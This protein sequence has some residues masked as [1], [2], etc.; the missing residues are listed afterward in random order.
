MEMDFKQRNESSTLLISNLESELEICKTDLNE[1]IAVNKRLFSDVDR[2]EHILKERDVEI[3][4]YNQQCFDLT[5]EALSLKM[6]KD[7]LRME[8]DNMDKKVSFIH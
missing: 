1:K 4:K 5:H 6:E 8:K 2:L 7:N 3:K